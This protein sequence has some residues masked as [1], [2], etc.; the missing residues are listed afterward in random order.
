MGGN[1]QSARK[2]P[3]IF[4]LGLKNEIRKSI[5]SNVLELLTDGG[6]NGTPI[7]SSELPLAGREPDNPAATTRGLH[8]E[9]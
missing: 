9:M 1:R 6:A 4:C 5:N 3:V 8:T 2:L 7:A